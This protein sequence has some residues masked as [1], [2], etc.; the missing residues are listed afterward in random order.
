MG[1]IEEL[2]YRRIAEIGI[3]CA[4]HY[5]ILRIDELD[6]SVTIGFQVVKKID[7]RH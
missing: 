4:Q 5:E 6:G 2:S 3:V 7:T 1:R